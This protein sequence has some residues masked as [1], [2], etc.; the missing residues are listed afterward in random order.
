VP[1]NLHPSGTLTIACQWARTAGGA[2]DPQDGPSFL[3]RLRDFVDADQ[4][5]RPGSLIG[6]VLAEHILP[7]FEGPVNAASL[8]LTDSLNQVVYGVSAADAKVMHVPER[9][10]RSQD[11]G[12]SPLDGRTFADIAASPYAA[13]YLDEVTHLH[14]WFHPGESRTPDQGYRHKVHRINGVY[15]FMINDREDQAKFGNFDGGAVMDTRYSLLQKALYGN[16]SEIVVVFDDWE[17]LAGKSFDPVQGVSVP[18][19]NP[20]QYHN[21]I[22]WLANHPWVRIANLKDLLALALADPSAFVVD[23]GTRTDLSLQTYEWLKHASEDSYHYWYYDANAGY[24]GNEQSFYDL[25]PVITG[26]QGDYHARGASVTDDG[27]PLPSGMKHGDLNTPGTLMYEAWRAIAAAPAGRLRELGIASYL[28][29]IYETAWHEEDAADYSD[30]DGYGAWTSPDATWDGVNTW[31]LRLQNHV[32]GVGLYAA[33]AAW[34]DS[35]ARGL[36]GSATVARA[37]DLDWDGEAEY[38]IEDRTSFAVFER[39]GA[40]CVL[41]CA[42]DAGD[43]DAEVVVGAPLTNPSAPGEEEYTGAAANRCSAFKEMNGGTYADAVYA[44]AAATN[45]W[46]FT[47]PDGLVQKTVTLAPGSRRLHAAYSE[48]AS[49]PLYV[50]FGL[51]PNPLDLVLHGQSHLVGSFPATR[52]YRL[53]NTS[54]RGAADLAWSAGVSF[55]A[56]PGDAGSDRRNLALTEEV[57]LCGDGAFDLELGLFADTSDVTVAV[58]APGV[59]ETFALSGPVPSPARGAAQLE[60]ALPAAARVRASVVD[61]QGRRL[62]ELD[63]GERAA[64]Q[65]R[66][67]LPARADDGTAL[68]PGLYFVCVRAGGREA[69]RRWVI[70]R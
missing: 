14:W 37:A 59:P 9:V 42:R 66:V 5:S 15:C 48:T 11:T 22:R 62:V 16:S 60:L 6:G 44:A 12:L 69:T 34:A 50:R 49:G 55:N 51:S 70:V 2:S 27:P 38:V 10:I 58:P 57:E 40:R 26:A 39:Y 64:G 47:S 54:G 45:G 4:S 52:E 67:D 61:V 56:A 35:A 7:Y 24:S 28:A 41:A 36:L 65:V 30:S 31:A 32:R 63:L 68:T 20:N 21:T 43:D 19:N 17:A 25:V 33:A 46:R 53:V 29:M 8:A 18:N 13:T 3:A 23:H 1:I